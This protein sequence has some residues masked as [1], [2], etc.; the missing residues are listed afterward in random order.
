M[1]RACMCTCMC[2]SAGRIGGTVCES[3]GVHVR[4]ETWAKRLPHTHRAASVLVPLKRGVTCL[5]QPLFKGEGMHRCKRLPVSTP[6]VQSSIMSRK[7]IG[8]S[9]FEWSAKP[10]GNFLCSV[11]SDCE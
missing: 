7:D 10:C 1:E 8:L 5:P 4:V 9:C 11:P 2:M 3:K 6:G